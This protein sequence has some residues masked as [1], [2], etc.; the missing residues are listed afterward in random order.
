MGTVLDQRDLLRLVSISRLSELLRMDRRTVSKRLA[1]ANLAPASKREGFPVYDGRAACEACLLVGSQG[2]DGAP[3]DPRNLKPMERRA[4]YQSERERM[5]VEAEA[6]QLI[7]AIE[8]QAEKAEMAR[9][10]VQFLDTL[11]DQLE[12][13]VALSPEQI[14]AMN[15]AITK[16][17]AALYAAAVAELE[18]DEAESA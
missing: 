4:W 11:G 16:Q 6:R 17:R 18:Q 3:V 14:D 7:P 9:T 8:V 5:A 12:R 15:R 2:E 1:D 13:D 10:F